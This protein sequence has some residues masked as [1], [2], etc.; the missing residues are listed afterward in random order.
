MNGEPNTDDKTNQERGWI[1]RFD[2][3]KI[4]DPEVIFQRLSK[5]KTI[6]TLDDNP[7][8]IK[9]LKN[10]VKYRNKHGGELWLSD[11]K[12]FDLLKSAKSEEG[13]AT[14]FEMLRQAPQTKSLAE[15]MQVRMVLSLP[16]SH[17]AVNE[18]W[19][20][21]RETPQHVFQILRL[22]DASL[23]NNPLFIQWL[24]YIE[25]Y[26]ARVGGNS[27]S[28]IYF[29]LKNAKPVN[30]VRFGTILQSLKETSDLKPLAGSL[31]TQLY[32]KL[33]LSP[34]AFERH[35]SIPV[36]IVASKLPTTDPRYGNL[37]AY[38]I[39]FAE[40]QGGDILDKVKTLVADGDLFNA[41]TVASKS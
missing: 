40:R 18:A 31:Q 34:L 7:T 35:L 27:Y 9:W 23:D 2:K 30:E 37:K 4:T 28:D 33:T 38:T 21:S 13:L 10:V 8:Y 22:G 3:L 20:N 12:V 39:Y 15:N 24:R 14:L 36:S 19:L 6:G 17:R 1:Q 5:T 16:S 26:A 11:D 25:L 32:Q 41:V 29:V